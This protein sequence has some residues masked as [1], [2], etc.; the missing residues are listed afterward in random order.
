[1]KNFIL[2][3]LLF[4]CLFTISK[5]T[6]AQP[7]LISNKVFAKTTETKSR[8][9]AYATYDFNT[10]YYKIDSSRFQ[11]SGSMSHYKV[12]SISPLFTYDKAMVNDFYEFSSD[13]VAGITKTIKVY[14]ASEN[15]T[16]RF[17]LIW[18]KGTSLWDTFNIINY[19]YVG[20]KLIQDEMKQRVGGF[21][22]MLVT[23]KKNFYTYKAGLLDEQIRYTFISP[24]SSKLKLESKTNYGYSGGV[25]ASVAVAKWDSSATVSP[26]FYN[27]NRMLLK[28]SGKDTIQKTLQSWDAIAGDWKNTE[29]TSYDFSKGIYSEDL[30]EKW[31]KSTSGWDYVQCDSLFYTSGV[32]TMHVTYDWDAAAKIWRP[33]SINGFTYSGSNLDK[34]YVPIWD[35]TKWTDNF[36]L[37]YY[38]DAKNNLSSIY[39]YYWNGSSYS[40]PSTDNSIVN[41]Y[42]EDYSTTSVKENAQTTTKVNLYPNPAVNNHSYL[43]YFTSKNTAAEIQI[44]DMMGREVMR[45]NEAGYIGDHS[46][47]IQLDNA[48]SGIYLVNLISEGKLEAQLKLV[49]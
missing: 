31:N 27:N 46:V 7:G 32:L 11:W 39:A 30:T 34:L 9:I 29:R 35:G 4:T 13:T 20:G 45:L 23:H 40:R 24:F 44:V 48:A 3:T 25:I 19:V 2:S 33:R 21:M 1:M 10:T 49:K 17:E 16:G 12:N 42:W 36:M 26:G 15:V 37:Q 14:D 47:L 18:N 8:I 6:K 41:Y 5:T 43:D 38:Y 22:G 28:F